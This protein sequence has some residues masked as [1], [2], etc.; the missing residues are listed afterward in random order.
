MCLHFG[1]INYKLTRTRIRS[2]TNI[3]FWNESYLL[4]GVRTG[5]RV[6]VSD[7]HFV[8]F[9]NYA[10]DRLNQMAPDV[11]F[12]FSI[13]FCWANFAVC[14]WEISVSWQLQFIV[15]WLCFGKKIVWCFNVEQAKNGGR[16][17]EIQR[18]YAIHCIDCN[19]FQIT[20]WIKFLFYI[21]AVDC[22]MRAL[23]N[24]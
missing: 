6:F 15:Q 20:S 14:A 18:R 8:V 23:T 3:V 16:N 11:R 4:A 2:T 19:L 12:N 5:L 17:N 10:I 24:H 21:S 9:G 7:F 1:G 13:S 22:I